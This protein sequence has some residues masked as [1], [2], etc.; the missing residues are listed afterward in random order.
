MGLPRSK[1]LLKLLFSSLL[2]FLGSSTP[3]CLPPSDRFAALP[4]SE[5]SEGAAT[6]PIHLPTHSAAQHEK[7][8]GACAKHKGPATNDQFSIFLKK[9]EWRNLLNIQNQAPARI[10]SLYRYFPIATFFSSLS[11]IFMALPQLLYR[12]KSNRCNC[13]PPP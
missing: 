5:P 1:T 7:C 3:S 6:D 2:G 11:F 10:L 4:P 13:C 8:R 12:Q 9:S